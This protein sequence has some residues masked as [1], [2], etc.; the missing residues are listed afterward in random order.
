M[1][2][3]IGLNFTVVGQSVAECP[4]FSVLLNVFSGLVGFFVGTSLIVIC[5]CFQ[6]LFLFVNVHLDVS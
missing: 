1:G 5:E 2:R 4:P 6:S 3:R